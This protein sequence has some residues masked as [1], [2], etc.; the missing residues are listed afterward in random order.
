MNQHSSDLGS[1][2]DIDYIPYVSVKEQKR[3]R[4][5]KLGTALGRQ[6]EDRL[7]CKWQVKAFLYLLFSGKVLLY[8]QLVPTMFGVLTESVAVEA[9]LQ[10]INVKIRTLQL[11]I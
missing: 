11:K 7:S 2:E 8:F 9:R 4:L 1:D 5:A 10:T 6:F 3:Q